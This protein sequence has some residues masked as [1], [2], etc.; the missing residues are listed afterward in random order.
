M[1]E[2]REQSE[3]SEFGGPRPDRNAQ[4]TGPKDRRRRP[5]AFLGP[6]ASSPPS[7][8]A[9]A[10]A[11]V[12]PAWLGRASLGDGPI[13]ESKRGGDPAQ[14]RPEGFRR[15]SRVSRTACLGRSVGYCRSA[16]RT[17]SAA[18][19]T[20]RAPRS[21]GWRLP[22][23]WGAKKSLASAG[24][25]G[26]ETAVE[27]FDEYRKGMVAR[28]GPVASA[29]LAGFTPAIQPQREAR[30]AVRRKAAI[31]VCVVRDLENGGQGRNRTADTGIFNPLLYRL[32]YLASG[33]SSLRADTIERVVIASR[34]FN[35]ELAKKSTTHRPI[36]VSFRADPGLRAR[37]LPACLCLARWPSRQPVADCQPSRFGET[38]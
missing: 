36:C 31:E 3:R 20:E 24:E 13:S 21:V 34:V 2:R 23:S 1:S 14:A 28:D 18:S 35:R 38:R 9:T 29:E 30:Q 27:V 26:G 22:R 33:T 25:A 15:R 19:P 32:S 17:Q 7:A 10:P 4:G 5:A 6:G 8:G 37:S 11:R 16:R 12:A